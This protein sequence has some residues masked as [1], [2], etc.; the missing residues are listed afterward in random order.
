[1]TRR[2]YSSV[3]VATT[4]PGGTTN[5]ATSI[6]I[7]AATGLP[8]SYPYTMIIDDDT[9]TMEA[10]EVTNRSGTTLTVMRGVDGTTAQSHSAGATI[11]HGWSARDLDEPNAWINA[12]HDHSTTALG[13]AVP[14]S[15]VTN[16]TTDLAAAG[17]LVLVTPSSIA[18]SGGSASLTGSVVSF[19]AVT[20]VSVN[21]AFTSTH[22]N[23][24][25]NMNVSGSTDVDLQI[26]LRAA[27]TDNTGANYSNANTSINFLSTINLP[28]GNAADSKWWLRRITNSV[29]SFKRLSLFSPAIAAERTGIEYAGMD[30]HAY[31]N[32]G[33]GYQSQLVAYDGFTLYPSSGTMS[34]RLRIYGYRNA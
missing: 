16:L 32:V 2:Y 24:L 25:I 21:G 17:G 14:Q 29:L 31:A 12:G 7:A 3:A 23:Y 22:D 1:M 9:T 18:N 20:S 4:I 6:V 11:H 13:G 34:G 10:V 33:T 30:N 28:E 8:A 15:S 27:G 26:R 19:D 5:V